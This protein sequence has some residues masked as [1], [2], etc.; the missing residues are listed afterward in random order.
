MKTSL[1]IKIAAIVFLAMSLTVA[2]A[3]F[4]LYAIL[5]PT[6]INNIFTQM[7][8]VHS[9]IDTLSKVGE[10]SSEEIINI[11]SSGSFDIKE[12]EA[13]DTEFE[14]SEIQ[15]K[16]NDISFS[17]NFLFFNIKGYFKYNGKI[18]VISQKMRENVYWMTTYCVIVIA[19]LC[20]L[21]GII[22]SAVISR[23]LLRP[24]RNINNTMDKVAKGRFDVTVPVPNNTDVGKLASN[25]NRM[26]KELSSIETLRG[27]FISNVSHEFKTPLSSIRGFAQLLLNKDLTQY[28]KDEYL[29][30]IIAETTRLSNLASNILRL[31]KLENQTTIKDKKIF[32]LD[33]SIREV[34]VIMESAWSAKN[35]NMDIDLDEINYFGNAEFM[36][37]IWQNLISNAIKFTPQNGN[38]LIKLYRTES[39]I[40]FKVFDDGMPIPP[41]IKE[42]IYDKFYQGDTSH[43][44]E[45]NGLGLAMTKRIVDLCEGNIRFEN[46]YGGGVTFY[47]ELPYAISDMM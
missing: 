45:G 18:Y 10:F 3:V 12:L 11:S 25:F 19:L 2:L 16:E 40:T 43:A 28:E 47:V 27:D 31:T 42:R 32:S 41:E 21:I 8:T 24:I 35:I 36:M 30:V 13:G 37:Q 17:S 22:I 38:M 14:K 1:Q 34:I 29:N 46:N 15:L 4:S 20:V 7:T 44:T 6:L 39:N 26:V 33:E 23:H 5:R 9:S